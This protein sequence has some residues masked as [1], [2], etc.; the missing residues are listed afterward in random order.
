MVEDD[1][2]SQFEE[3]STASTLPF[4]TAAVCQACGDEVHP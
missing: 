4:L 2:D 3:F 1:T